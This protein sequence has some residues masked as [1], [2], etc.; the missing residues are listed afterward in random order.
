MMR[1]S[2]VSAASLALAAVVAVGTVPMPAHAQPTSDHT[3][4]VREALAKIDTTNLSPAAK[5]LLAK[6]EN[7]TAADWKAMGA[8]GAAAAKKLGLETDW[9][10]LAVASDESCTESDF[11]EWA[12]AAIGLDNLTPDELSAMEVLGNAG[13]FDMPFVDAIFYGSESKTNTYGA[14]GEYTNALT[15]EIKDLKRF[16]DIDSKDIQLVPAHGRDVF[17]SRERVARAFTVMFGPAY[18]GADQDNLAWADIILAALAKVPALRMGGNPLFTLNAMAIPDENL[19]DGSKITK[20]IVVGDGLLEGVGALVP[21]NVGPRM[22]L[23][24]EF[25]HQVQFATDSLPEGDD[26]AAGRHAE[27]EAD[28]YAGYYLVN[29]RGAALNAK[30]VADAAKSA[31]EFGDCDVTRQG[32]H[33]TPDQRERSVLWADSVANSA[34]NQGHILPARTYHSEFEA[35]LPGIV[36]G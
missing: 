4:A 17:T 21:G 27:L 36:T 11:G 15:S 28:A 30:R 12:Q 22:V 6:V 24:H 7:W 32:H 35:A 25:G 3:T 20:R 31:W 9:S 1:K 14:N 5:A 33:G 13:A 16:W 10:Q 2:L 23:A 19:P 34:S 26:V 18:Q 29:S 8:A